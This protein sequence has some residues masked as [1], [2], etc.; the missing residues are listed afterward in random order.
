MLYNLANYGLFN[1][2]YSERM[3]ITR[4]KVLIRKLIDQLSRDVH[5]DNKRFENLKTAQKLLNILEEEA[6]LPSSMLK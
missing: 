6:Q 4:N 2:Y 5:D 3:R 1:L